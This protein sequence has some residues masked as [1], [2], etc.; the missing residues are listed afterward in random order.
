[1][2]IAEV[3]SLLVNR[4]LFVE[5]TTD[6]GIKGVGESGA[7][8]FLDASK[9]AI[10]LFGE[11]LVG[12]D[13][14]QIEHHWQYLY[15]CW[16][17][18]G[19]AIMGALSAVDIALW[20]IAGKYHDAPVYELLGG[21]VRDKARVYYHVGGRNLEEVVAN[22]K[23]AKEEGFNAVGHLSPFLDSSRSVPYFEPYS[24]KIGDAVDNVYAF[25]EAVGRDVDLCLELHRRLNPAEAI[26]FSKQI[27]SAL[28]M[29]LEDPTTPDNFD[30]T[31]LIAAKT[32]IPIA[33]G[34]RFNS[35]QD[36]AMLMKR[37]GVAYI[38]PDVCMVGGITAAKKIAALA[39]AMDVLVVPHS[40][41]SPVST[42]ACLQISAVIPNF[43]LFEYTG[44]DKPAL[45]ERYG[46]TGVEKGVRKKDV[47]SRTF[48]C[49]DGFMELPD[50]A[51]LGI[52]L[53]ENAAEKYPY[54]KRYMQTRVSVDGSVIDQ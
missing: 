49:K 14:L 34:E 30:S 39:E 6:T 33:T 52:C 36:F 29:F 10:D 50:I 48:A 19:A 27:E 38:R 31:A 46:S 18:R 7:W 41:L 11:Y 43:S 32:N 22:L 16:H 23:E 1:M 54:S 37:D 9:E 3:K 26:S 21:K 45:S 25:R 12:K 2:K 44:D 5:I 53:A 51:G 47:V 4:Y 13:P 28:P 17:F 40:P 35:L 20:D 15:R 42:A 24:K 8:G